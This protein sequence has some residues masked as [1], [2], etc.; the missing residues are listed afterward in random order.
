MYTVLGLLAAVENVFPPVPADTAVALG[1]LLSHRGVTSP[2]LVFTVTIIA[3]TA[4]AALIYALARRMGPRFGQSR[5]GRRLLPPGALVAVERN[6]LRWGLPAIFLCRLIPGVRAI[7][8]PFAGLVGLSPARAL[9]P[10]ALASAI[11]YAFVTILG[12]T[13]GAEWDHVIGLISS[14]NHWLAL[15]GAGVLLLGGVWYLWRRRSRTRSEPVATA[16]VGGVLRRVL[17]T[18]DDP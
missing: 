16:V 12:V 6:Y 18:R 3:N 13:L 1:A 9:V 2:W 5:W 10:I 7:V 4:S 11:W 14:A 15:V 17:P 8:P